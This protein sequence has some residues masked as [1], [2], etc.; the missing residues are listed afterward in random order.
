MPN[1]RGPSER[2]RRLHASVMESVALYGAPIWAE[3]FLESRE[4]LRIIRGVQRPVVNRV[5][6]AYRTVSRDAALLFLPSKDATI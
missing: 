6:S 5:C 2:K 1:L 4:A 3:A